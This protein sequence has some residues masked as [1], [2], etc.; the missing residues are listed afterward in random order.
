[1]GRPEGLGGLLLRLVLMAHHGAPST[2]SLETFEEQEMLHS[3]SALC[4]PRAQRFFSM[5]KM[6]ARFSRRLKPSKVL[7]SPHC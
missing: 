2:A 3:V 1:M 7:V 6:P 4:S 5:R